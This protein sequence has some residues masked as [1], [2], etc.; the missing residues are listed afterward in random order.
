[1]PATF[2]SCVEDTFAFIDDLRT[3]VQRS[4]QFDLTILPRNKALV[5]RYRNVYFVAGSLWCRLGS[6]GAA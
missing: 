2:G 3:Q 5:F 1:M 6:C 4:G